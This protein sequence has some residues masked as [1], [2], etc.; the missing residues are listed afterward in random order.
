MRLSSLVSKILT[1]FSFSL[2]ERVFLLS[3][4]YAS[5]FIKGFA[6]L[7]G[8]GSINLSA[9]RHRWCTPAHT[10]Q[11]TAGNS[12]AHNLTCS[13]IGTCHLSSSA[14]RHRT[15]EQWS[16]VS[17]T[18]SS[19]GAR[20]SV[21][22]SCT[23]CQPTLDP[24]PSY[25]SL[26]Q[27]TTAYPVAPSYPILH[28]ILLPPYLTTQSYSILP[29]LTTSY[30]VLHYILLTSYPVLPYPTTANHTLHR[31]TLHSPA[32]LPCP[33]LA[34]SILHHPTPPYTVS[35]CH[36]NLVLHCIFCDATLYYL[37]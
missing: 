14:V 17:G 30:I 33:S 23:Y 26:P 29:P 35:Y 3:C 12:L 19:S 9:W 15:K 24:T 8:C 10:V 16:R 6:Q 7:S 34:Y 18:A 21:W 20:L 5:M 36:P 22:L 32:S 25:L 37:I 4:E 13:V 28:C 1:T 27:Q 11:R 2:N 31:P